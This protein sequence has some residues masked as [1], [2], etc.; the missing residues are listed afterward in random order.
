MNYP[1]DAIELLAAE[2]VVGTLDGAARR[3]FEQLLRLR[4]DVRH[5]TWA[6]EQR[7]QGL[8]EEI[9]PVRPPRSLWRSIRRRIGKGERMELLRPRFAM[10][11]VTAAIAVIAFWLG[12]IIPTDPVPGDPEHMAIFT[13]D[14]A[15]TLWVISLDTDTGEMVAQSLGV[16]PLDDD[17]VHEL[18]ALPA[19]GSPLSLGL[20]RVDPGR[21]ERALAPDRIAA[22]EQSANLA[23]SIEPTGGSPTGLPT[24]PVVHQASL[25]SL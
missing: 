8:C 6:W 22:V 12:G 15:R 21:I 14:E 16:A 17:L 4:A 19:G 23:I 25:V 10:A 7:L 3:R 1:P 20:L 9:E 18:W 2:Y 24:G 5:A 11:A 13:D